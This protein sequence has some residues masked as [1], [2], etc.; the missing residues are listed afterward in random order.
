MIRRLLLAAAAAAAA[1]APVAAASLPRS[2]TVTSFDRIR[3]EGP[4]AVTLAVGRAP[5]ARAE[6]SPAQLDAIDLRVEGRTLVLRQRSGQGGGGIGGPVRISL[7]TPDLRS[8]ALIGAGS[9]AIDRMAGLTIDLA[10]QGAGSLDVGTVAADRVNAAIQGS[11][12]LTLAGKSKVAALIARGTP[13]LAATRLDADQVQVAAEGAGD[14]AASAR[15]RAGISAAGTVRVQLAGAP[16][17]TLK[18]SGSAT[19]EGCGKAR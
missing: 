14:V 17:C 11:G 4:Y 10:V 18:V 15:S 6:G 12:S 1:S 16:A 19:V 5:L 8:A 7:A 3:V 9:L 2:F 13:R